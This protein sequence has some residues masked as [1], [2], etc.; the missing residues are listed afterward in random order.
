MVRT[1]P[2]PAELLPNYVKPKIDFREKASSVIRIIRNGE[3]DRIE[4]EPSE[5]QNSTRTSRHSAFV[6]DKNAVEGCIVGKIQNGSTEKRFN[7]I[8]LNLPKSV[9]RI[10]ILSP[11]R[12]TYVENFV[13]PSNNPEKQKNNFQRVINRIVETGI[14]VT[15][16]KLPHMNSTGENYELIDGYENSNLKTK[17]PHKSN[18]LTNMAKLNFFK[19]KDMEQKRDKSVTK[20]DKVDDDQ[21]KKDR[22]YSATSL[23]TRNFKMVDDLKSF[24][25]KLT[26]SAKSG[27]SLKSKKNLSQLELNTSEEPRPLSP[28]VPKPETPALVSKLKTSQSFHSETDLSS[29]KKFTN[30][31][32]VAH[33]LSTFKVGKKPDTIKENGQRPSDKRLTALRRPVYYSSS[34]AD[35]D[36]P[37]SPRKGALKKLGPRDSSANRSPLKVRWKD[38]IEVTNLEVDNESDETFNT[39]STFSQQREA[40][41]ETDESFSDDELDERRTSRKYLSNPPM[42]LI[43]EKRHYFRK[44]E[45][46]QMEFNLEPLHSTGEKLEAEMRQRIERLKNINDKKELEKEDDKFYD[47][48][49]KDLDVVLFE[50]NSTIEHVR[51]SS[52]LSA[53]NNVETS[54]IDAEVSRFMDVKVDDRISEIAVICRQFVNSSKSMISAAFTKQFDIKADVRDAMNSLCSL[55]VKCLE[56]NFNFLYY[57]QKLDETR[58]LLIQILSLLN[59][60]RTTLNIICLASANQLS[61]SNMSLLMKQATGLANEISLLIRHFKLLF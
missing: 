29:K 26:S 12:D 3:R 14:Q 31:P 25:D 56:T 52:M 44:C 33:T 2:K 37:E 38:I 48:V 10:S 23:P 61:E 57:N 20:A 8:R 39:D 28:E 15:K 21:S 58:H 22:Q 19:S 45:G 17:P 7:S 55:V 4:K 41:P 40:R 9:E 16:S 50:V 24:F 53:V 42:D 60:F 11:D 27:G 5:T 1:I 54:S 36:S 30:K 18:T 32:I 46:K 43:S 49:Y 51:V 47:E 59:T 34:D 35:Q 13:R 6:E